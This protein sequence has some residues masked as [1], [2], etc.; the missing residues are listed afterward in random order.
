MAALHI[1]ERPHNEVDLISVEP[2]YKMSML[3]Y[4]SAHERAWDAALNQ[5]IEDAQAAIQAGT[6]TDYDRALVAWDEDHDL[7]AEMPE[8]LFEQN[9]DRVE[10][11]LFD[12]VYGKAADAT[13]TEGPVASS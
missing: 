6:A 4:R 2:S 12:A 13:L 5:E 8:W 1:T 7:N 3:A 11:R 9:L 10:Q